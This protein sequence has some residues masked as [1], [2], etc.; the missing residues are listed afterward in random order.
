MD[1]KTFIQNLFNNPEWVTYIILIQFPIV[2]CLAIQCFQF[3]KL[4]FKEFKLISYAW[5]LNFFY[6][7]SKII[8]DNSIQDAE[9]KLQIRT[10]LDILNMCFFVT[11]VS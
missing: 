11:L 5:I 3:Y 4:G 8:M 1:F 2:F 10:T 7:L 9:I 6:L